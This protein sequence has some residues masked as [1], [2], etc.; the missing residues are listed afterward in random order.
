[1]ALS[2]T[3]E[4]TRNVF[5]DTLQLK[6]FDAF[7]QA[8]PWPSPKGNYLVDSPDSACGTGTKAPKVRHF[9]LIAKS[10]CRPFGPQ[11]P[12]MTSNHGL[13]AVAIQC[14]TFGAQASGASGESCKQMPSREGEGEKQERI[15][16]SKA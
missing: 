6:S 9:H 11:V 13:T 8:S 2:I 16:E 12:K 3:S 5:Q 4:I 1:M 7:A 10:Q 14:R 15:A